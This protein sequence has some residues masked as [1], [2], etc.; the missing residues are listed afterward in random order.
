MPTSMS[1]DVTEETLNAHSSFPK[2]S[3]TRGTKIFSNDCGN[4]SHE[5]DILIV[6]IEVKERV[7]ECS[8]EMQHG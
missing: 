5:A 3:G 2:S 4:F 6:R 8:M 7:E 1:G